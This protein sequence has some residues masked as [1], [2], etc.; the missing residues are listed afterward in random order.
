MAQSEIPT[1]ESMAEN[2]QGRNEDSN[3]SD[4][5][6]ELNM[7]HD[8]RPG[9]FQ[10]DLAKV[11]EALHSQGILNEVQII[12]VDGQDLVGRLSNG[13]VVKYDSMDLDRN[14]LSA[15][16]RY[17]GNNNPIGGRD[18]QI[19]ADGSGQITVQSG[20]TGHKIAED[21]LRA[22]GNEEPTPREIANYW[23]EMQVTNNITGDRMHPGDVL[24]LPTHVSG[25]ADTVFNDA[26]AND[27]EE[28]KIAEIQTNT[29]NALAAI[30]K[31]DHWNW[32]KPYSISLDEI[33]RGL[34]QGN[35]TPEQAA[36][37]KFLATNYN[38]LKAADGLIWQDQLER[39]S[40]QQIRYAE[41]E[42]FQ[43]RKDG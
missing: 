32:G 29:T 8:R 1:G 25:G 43:Q 9:L 13:A 36:G 24:K 41:L 28:A 26:R 10:E 11:N 18:T 17:I 14:T 15:D 38:Q 21:V 27:A 31:T 40:Q 5:A 42:S 4:L 22:Q 34:T 35:L 20:D 16:V 2:I 30:H 39:W 3:F 23:R 7:A 37:Y 19:N 33:N 6:R 12:G